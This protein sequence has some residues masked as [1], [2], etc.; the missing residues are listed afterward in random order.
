MDIIQERKV[1]LGD[2]LTTQWVIEDKNGFIIWDTFDKKI[3]LKQ[4]EII[5]KRDLK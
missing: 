5:K 1:L 4:K 3:M 2:D